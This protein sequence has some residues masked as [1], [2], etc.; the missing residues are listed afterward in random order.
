MGPTISNRGSPHLV[1]P[2]REQN[3]PGKSRSVTPILWVFAASG[4]TSLIYEVLWRRLLL[5]VLGG[6]TWATAITLSAFMAGLGLGAILVGRLADRVGNSLRWYGFA[7]IAIGVYAL[8]FPLLC[9]GVQAVHDAAFPLL[10][11]RPLW[12]RTGALAAAFVILLPPTLLMGGTFPLL[13]RHYLRLRSS[14]ESGIRD[15]YCFNTAGAVAGAILTGF[16]LIRFVGT[17]MAGNLAVAANLAIGSIAVA[18]S[19]RPI[20]PALQAPLANPSKR[21]GKH[22]VARHAASNS[23]TAEISPVP[24]RLILMILALSGLTALSYETLWTR[25]LVF[26]LGHS[27]VSFA[28]MLS[29]FLCGLALG[30][31]VL[32]F[33]GKSQAVLKA[34]L[35]EGLIGI[36]AVAT[37]WAAQFLH[38]IS[39]RFVGPSGQF[40]YE[41]MVIRRYVLAVLF[42]LPTAMLFGLAFPLLVGVCT[43]GEKTTGNEVGWAYGSNTFGAILGPL[44]ATLLFVP[45]WGISGAVIATA[46]LNVALAIF[47]LALVP[48]W[49]L[50]R[51]GMW[52]FGAAIPFVLLA[53]MV[54]RQI[55]VSRHSGARDEKRTRLLYYKE[56]AAAT[57]AVFQL[58]GNFAKILAIDGVQQVPTDADSIQVFHLL[59]HL[60]FLVR[61]DVRE[62]LVTAFGGGITLGSILTHPVERVEAVEI[63]PAVLPA[64]RVLSEENRRAFDDPRLR[65]IVADAASYVRA[66][67]RQYDAII[68][69]AT[70]PAAAESWVLYTREFYENCKRRL[71]PGGVMC[72]WVPLHGLAPDDLRVILHTFQSVYPHATLWFARGYSILLATE[73][74]LALDA[75]RIRRALADPTIGP[76]LTDAFLN[77]PIA[78]LKNLA[79]TEDGVARLGEAARLATNNRSPLEFSGSRAHSRGTVG[80]NCFLIAEAAQGFVPVSHLSPDE[81]SALEKAVAAR[82]TYYRAVGR[83]NDGTIAASVPLLRGAAERIP[84]DRDIEMFAVAVANLF[85]QS[86]ATNPQFEQRL[87]DLQALARLFPD[88]PMVQ[89]D[90]GRTLLALAR[91]DRERKTL[92]KGL[93][94]LRAAGER[95][96][97]NPSIQILVGQEFLLCEQFATAQVFF[98]R[99]VHLAPDNAV[100]WT[101]LGS[102]Y[103]A[104]GRTGLSRQ[105]VERAL[106]IRPDL[107]PALELRRRIGEREKSGSIPRNTDPSVRP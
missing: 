81:Q 70:H 42:M 99:A 53:A 44:I 10:E 34:A 65:V 71:R 5:L 18:L 48:S 1:P 49:S 41:W 47:L 63:C 52:T 28:I 19:L 25:I 24:I 89:I 105:A 64:A 97:Q 61:D 38:D 6:S 3:E 87:N 46:A 107:P 80:R 60:P 36:S 91:R 96:A 106:S 8:V 37:L 35:I 39:I 69:D 77:S 68:S 9:A 33:V 90:F 100:T 98:E 45:Q 2:S 4:A 76:S 22:K 85:S 78:L 29:S 30:A 7:E 59:G 27:T 62:V 101:S 32:R 21:A 104:Q 86:I 15:L 103:L 11:S 23:A 43:R 79:L 95:F 73:Q 56:E 74:P 13:V 26:V 82:S 72:Q 12:L 94:V 93:G 75:E 14:V 40:T 54:P 20:A 102:C 16:F 66:T 50:V 57:V 31:W 58:P 55:D 83:W 88:E 84:G 92:E 17:R 67:P 51:K